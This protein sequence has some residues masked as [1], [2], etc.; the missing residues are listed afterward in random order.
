MPSTMPV[1]MPA[2]NFI[3]VSPLRCLSIGL[4]S[5]LLEIVLELAA[6]AGVSQLA[7]CFRFD[8]ADALAGDV[9]LLAD[10]LEGAGAPVLEAEPELEH[11]PLAAGQGVQDRL[12]LLLE[13]LVRRRLG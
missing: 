2:M 8:L 5:R 10:L 6:P 13:E 12:D 4:S 9:E 11:S 1:A 3:G 7:K